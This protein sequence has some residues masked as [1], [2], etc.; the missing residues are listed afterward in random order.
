MHPEEK[1]WEK[2]KQWYPDASL[3]V[4]KIPDSRVRGRKHVMIG[5]EL[6]DL[7]RQF[8]QSLRE[9][10]GL[11]DSPVCES[12]DVMSVK[13]ASSYSIVG[14]HNLS[15]KKWDVIPWAEKIY[16]GLDDS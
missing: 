3:Q 5:D 4:C 7:S 10:T 8:L 6:A 1:Y 9:A 14:H 16:Y 11:N 13:D 2:T 15:S 12:L